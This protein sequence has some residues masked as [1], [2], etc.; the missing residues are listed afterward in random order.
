M[1]LLS[2]AIFHAS[3]CFSSSVA[4]T[5]AFV[6]NSAPLMGGTATSSH[7]EESS[8]SSLS[9]VGGFLQ[10]LFPKGSSPLT[11]GG[12]FQARDLMKN[13]IQDKKCFATEVGALSFGEACADD[14]VYNDCYEQKPFVGKEVRRAERGMR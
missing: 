3:L 11:L 5:N 6:P 9:V 12:E 10:D 8:S 7:H 2:R 13:L 14:V 1:I 4:V